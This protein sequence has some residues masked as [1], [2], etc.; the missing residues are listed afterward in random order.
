MVAHCLAGCAFWHNAAEFACTVYRDPVQASICETK[1]KI[2]LDK[3][4]GS[5]NFSVARSQDISNFLGL[6]YQGW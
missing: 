3:L 6:L 1:V 2:C 5:Y 4:E